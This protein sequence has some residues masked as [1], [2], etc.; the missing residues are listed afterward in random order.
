MCRSREPLLPAA[1]HRGSTHSA[2]AQ[3]LLSPRP[4]LFPMRRGLVPSPVATRAVFSRPTP[5][6]SPRRGDN[7]DVSRRAL[8]TELEID[9]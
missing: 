4:Q 9:R 1:T 6:R 7:G 3:L 5:P 8:E 2:N